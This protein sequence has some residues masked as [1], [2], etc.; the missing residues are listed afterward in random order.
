M[1]PWKRPKRTSVIAASVPSMVATVAEMSATRS[2]TQAASRSAALWKSETYHLVENPPHT[3][4]SLRLVEG[5][6]DEQDDRQI[7]EGEAE[8][9]RG[10]VEPGGAPHRPATCG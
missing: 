9:H 3:V 5:I 8:R 2:V 10:D 7:E 4:T 1:R 6:D